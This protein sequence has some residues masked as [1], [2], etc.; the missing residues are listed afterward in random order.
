MSDPR[1]Q[2]D[3]ARGLEQTQVAE[4]PWKN[5]GTGRPTGYPNNVPYFRTDL[6]WW[7]YYDGTRQL[8]AH[9][10]TFQFPFTTYSA[11]TEDFAGLEKTPVAY[12]VWPVSWDY[13][14]NTGITNTGAAFWTFRLRAAG[15][16]TVVS[17]DTSTA[18]PSTQYN[19]AVVAGF[20]SLSTADKY[21][22][23]RAEKTGVAS[24]IDGYFQLRYKLIIP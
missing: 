24:N 6:G 10:Y 18:A 11:T 19:A 16:A 4:R 2:R 14:I 20:A 5:Y 21:L 7:I 22:N 3:I 17:F 13:G 1:S 8:T 15:T 23:I 9:D 12:A